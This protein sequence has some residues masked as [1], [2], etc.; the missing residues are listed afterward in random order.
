MIRK[1]MHA[2]QLSPIMPIPPQM[3]NIRV[4]VIVLP[5]VKTNKVS[6]TAENMK[7]YLKQYAN[8]ALIEQEKNA[9]TLNLKEKYGNL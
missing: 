8:P 3:Q 5:V 9:W 4:E 2:Q 1:I 6:H 7:G